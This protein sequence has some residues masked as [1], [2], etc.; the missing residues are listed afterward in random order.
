MATF[1]GATSLYWRST[2]A[3]SDSGGLLKEALKNRTSWVAAIFLLGYVGVEVALGGW[4]VV[5]M[6]RER[7]GGD[8]ESG[9]V[10]TG[11]W[12]GITVG[13]VLLGFVTPKIGEQLAVSVSHSVDSCC[14]RI[15]CG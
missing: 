3:S 8:F 15:L 10:A 1:W 2:G 5:F 11:F 14:E 12:I 13:R 6:A 9:M 4:I 7:D